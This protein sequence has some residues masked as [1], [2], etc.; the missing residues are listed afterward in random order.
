M[1][2]RLRSCV[3]CPRCHTR[4]IIGANPYRNGSYISGNLSEDS[5]VRNLYCCCTGRFGLL[6]FKLSEL[7]TYSVSEWAYNR[8]YGSPDEIVL[9][10]DK[11]RKAS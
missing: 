6:Q 7:M 3:E 1:P 8:G 11:K 5:D 9:V 2:L 4:Y 10:D